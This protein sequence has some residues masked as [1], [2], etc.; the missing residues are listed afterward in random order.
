MCLSKKTLDAAFFENWKISS[1]FI[2]FNFL[3][4][5]KDE[6]GR[7]NCLICHKQMK[8]RGYLKEHVEIH[9]DGLLFPCQVCDAKLRPRNA[10]RDHLNKYDQIK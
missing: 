7:W 9:F 8:S 4:F 3:R 2:L 6:I 1:F 10:H 5:G